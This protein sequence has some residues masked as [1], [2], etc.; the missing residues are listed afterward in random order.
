MNAEVKN[1]TQDKLVETPNSYSE[2]SFNF[3]LWAREVKFQLVA[4][5]QRRSKRSLGE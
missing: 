1:Q 2:D 5:L 4:A 3:D